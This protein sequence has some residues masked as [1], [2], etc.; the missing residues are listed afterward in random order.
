MYIPG[1]AVSAGFDTRLSNLG[2]NNRAIIGVELLRATFKELSPSA[3]IQKT[4]LCLHTQTFNSRVHG[5]ILELLHCWHHRSSLECCVNMTTSAA[6]VF[7]EDFNHHSRWEA[8]Q[9][10]AVKRASPL[11]KWR[12]DA[13]LLLP[14]S[15]TGL[16]SQWAEECFTPGCKS[17][18]STSAEQLLFFCCY[19]L[20]E[21]SCE[22][23]CNHWYTAA[24]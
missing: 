22:G 8:S 3:L 20:T 21:A 12:C 7:K 23:Q 14:S 18:R 19:C 6:C 5:N 1:F 13:Q 16:R 17:H 9:R 15:N 2:Q 24:K 11:P 10:K 4:I